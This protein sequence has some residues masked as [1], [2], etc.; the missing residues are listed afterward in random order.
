MFGEGFLP[1]S[2][3]RTWPQCLIC[4]KGPLEGAPAALIYADNG[5]H[6][7][8]DKKRVGETEACV[9]QY[10]DSLGLETHEKT[11]ASVFAESLG[12]RFDAESLEVRGT[13]DRLA[14]ASQ[15]LIPLIGGRPTSS[16]ELEH[17]I[18]HIL[19]LMLLGRLSMS[20]VTHS[21]IF[22]RAHYF[23]R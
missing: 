6:V 11:E 18:G 8:S 17:I 4:K 14:R 9:S 22:I 21:Y 20:W 2:S 19:T 1:S 10:L 15:G 12:V 7:G 13:R 3:S 5:V 16:Q 23:G